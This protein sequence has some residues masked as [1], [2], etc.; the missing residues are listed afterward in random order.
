MKH[1]SQTIHIRTGVTD[2]DAAFYL[3][4]MNAMTHVMTHESN[5]T[6]FFIRQRLPDQTIPEG[7]SFVNQDNLTILELMHLAQVILPPNDKAL[8]SHLDA[9]LDRVKENDQLSL[10]SDGKALSKTFRECPLLAQLCLEIYEIEEDREFLR[11]VFPTLIRL[12]RSRYSLPV[13]SDKHAP[14]TWDNPRQLALDTGMFTFDIWEATGQGLDIQFVESPALAAMLF[15]EARAL[16]KIADILGDKP[17]QQSFGNIENKLRKKMQAFW[18]DSLQIWSYQDCQSQLSPTRELYYPGPAHE[19]TEIHKVFT[20]PQ[21]LQCHL[22]TRDNGTRDSHITIRGEAPGGEEIIEDFAPTD[23]RWFA[24]RA[25]VTT[26]NLYSVLH[27]ITLNGMQPDD[28]FLI[29]TAN[30]S[31]SDELAKPKSRIRHP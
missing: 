14:L 27:S 22:F 11:N 1:N 3:A 6:P 2:W 18:Q 23:I 4:Q 30:L 24:G 12:F 13:G 19:S 29:E 16:H 20:V 9:Y 8:R 17:Q 7:R 28:R 5:K 25:H 26:T 15:R 31:Q 21:R 10:H